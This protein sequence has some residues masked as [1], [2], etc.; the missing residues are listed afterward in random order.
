[1]GMSPKQW[2]RVKE[3]FEAALE[4]SPK[5]RDAFLERKG[6]DEVVR[7]EVR[8]LLAE[9]DHLGRGFLSTLPSSDPSLHPTDSPERLAPGEVLSARF[10]IINFLAAGGM[11]E[12]YKAEDLRLDRMV[13][14]KFLSKELAEDR[15]SLER[16]RR[17]AKA[18]SALNHPN[19][20]TVYDF[21]EDAGRAFIA[22]E[23][24]DGET[25]SARIQ[26]GAL[27]LDETLKIA[28]AI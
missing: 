19:I 27:S 26:R 22:M 17:E 24:L 16:F 13:V 9:Q 5:Q 8:R 11:G 14:L 21:G 2:D 28:V 25:L 20:C 18:A 10:R 4:C 15:Q 23:Y 6:E 3:L 12:V 1:M 7:D